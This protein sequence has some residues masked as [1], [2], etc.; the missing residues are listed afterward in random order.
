MTNPGY[1][2]PTPTPVPAEPQA[3]SPIP[4]VIPSVIPSTLI[5]VP[6]HS[7]QQ[8]FFPPQAN[9]KPIL[10]IISICLTGVSILGILTSFILNSPP[11][12]LFITPP[13]GFILSIIS[14]AR[15]EHP[16]WLTW[17]S[18][19]LSGLIVLGLIGFALFIIFFISIMFFGLVQL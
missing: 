1:I 12:I 5:G 7:P 14:L 17:T 2:P 8:M 3:P 16:R 13:A 9:K 15:K 4:S 18:F 6:P 11:Y 19:T 10:A